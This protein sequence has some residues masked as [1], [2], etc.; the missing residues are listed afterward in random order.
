MQSEIHTPDWAVVGGKAVVV[1]GTTSDLRREVEI[2]RVTDTQITVEQTSTMGKLRQRF[3]KSNSD[4]SDPVEISKGSRY[5]KDLLLGPDDQR[6]EIHHRRKEG[7]RISGNAR[8]L[9][10]SFGN[11]PELD[12]AREA[13]KALQEWIEANPE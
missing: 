1:S 7:Q 10:R 6:H 4:F 2:I 11:K 3:R 8:A 9:C 13:V 12:V 5:Y